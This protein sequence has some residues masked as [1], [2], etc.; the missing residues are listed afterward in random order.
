MCIRELLSHQI[1][2]EAIGLRDGTVSEVAI[3]K[4]LPDLSGIHTVTL[5]LGAKNQALYYPYILRLKP[6]RVIFN[7]G[8]ENPEFEK[9]LVT[10]GIEVELACTLVMLHSGVF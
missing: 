2:V 9:I 8:A 5:Y 1:P 4:G 10:A 3:Q 7:P 6:S